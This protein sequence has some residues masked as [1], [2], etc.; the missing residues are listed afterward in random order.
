[1]AVI[2]FN[3]EVEKIEPLIWKCDCGNCSF[4]IHSN[5]NLECA[6]CNKD[7]SHVTEHMQ[8]VRKWTRKD[9]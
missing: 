4:M 6:E 2:N 1:M 3:E 5:G 9:S 7:H 8:T